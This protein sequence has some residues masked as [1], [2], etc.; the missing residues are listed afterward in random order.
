MI[1]TV[2][3]G[4]KNLETNAFPFSKDEW[5]ATMRFSVC[6]NCS[7]AKC[8]ALSS[9]WR[10]NAPPRRN[11]DYAI[12]LALSDHLSFEDQI[13]RYSHEL[14]TG[15][16]LSVPHG[17]IAEAMGALKYPQLLTMLG[18][19]PVIPAPSPSAQTAAQQRID[20]RQ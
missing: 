10:C 3:K 19:H 15:Q 1:G 9:C 20:P 11:S 17:A 5:V 12:S 13:P 18:A 6:F 16:K 14:R 7:S 4:T 2:K 8:G